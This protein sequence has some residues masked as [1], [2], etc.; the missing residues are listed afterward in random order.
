MFACHFLRIVVVTSIMLPFRLPWMLRVVYQL[1]G[2]LNFWKP[3]PPFPL[4]KQSR[5]RLSGDPYDSILLLGFQLSVLIHSETKSTSQ[6]C[7]SYISH[8]VVSTSNIHGPSRYWLCSYVSRVCLIFECIASHLHFLSLVLSLS[9]AV[10]RLNKHNRY[11]NLLNQIL[12]PWSNNYHY[13]TVVY[14]SSLVLRNCFIEYILWLVKF[15]WGHLW[16]LIQ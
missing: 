16:A 8:A 9:K 4:I 10:S 6:A 11:A 5:K 14:I 13:F 3:W 1:S 15:I 2:L 12:F 7:L